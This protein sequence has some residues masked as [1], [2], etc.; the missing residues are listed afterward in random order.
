MNIN[1][2]KSIRCY[3]LHVYIFI[4]TYL[5]VLAESGPS[6]SHFGL[7]AALFA[8]VVNAWPLLK[9]PV[10]AIVKLSLIMIA[11]M[12]LGLLPWVD[13]YAHI[14]GFIGGLL[15]SFSLFPYINFDVSDERAAEK[16]VQ[17]NVISYVELV[18]QFFW[19]C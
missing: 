14:F 19:D 11:M 2:I 9:H 5:L 16:A 7:L 8:E 15:I 6:G 1:I 4:F 10:R 3:A 13:N 18:Q 12:I 17:C